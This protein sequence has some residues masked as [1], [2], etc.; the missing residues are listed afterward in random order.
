MTIHKPLSCL[1][2]GF[3]IARDISFRMTSTRAGTDDCE[4]LARSFRSHTI[5]K[6]VVTCFRACSSVVH[7]ID[8]IDAFQN[9]TVV[10]PSPIVI[11][12]SHLLHVKMLEP[13]STFFTH[14]TAT[15][16]PLCYPAC[17]I[18]CPN[19]RKPGR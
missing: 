19:Y 7:G 18:P 10:V 3:I 2:T 16:S 1:Y 9:P 12:P 6:L 4:D 5:E 14:S 11:L 17:L 13:L 8:Y 15:Q